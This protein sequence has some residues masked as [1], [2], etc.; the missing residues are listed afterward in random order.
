[1]VSKH[2]YAIELS[3]MNNQVY[4]LN[5][6]KSVKNDKEIK[7]T[8]INENLKVI[9][10]TLFYPNR[11]RKF[12]P[13]YKVLEA[14]HIKKIIRKY[15]KMDVV[16]SFST[17]FVNLKKFQ[18]DLTIYH[19]VDLSTD[20]YF[21]L[22]SE[23]SDFLLGV[24][25]DILNKFSKKKKYL[26]EHGLSSYF[27]NSNYKNYELD[28]ENIN[29]CYCGNMDSKAINKKI[30]LHLIRNY[31]KIKFHFI[32]PYNSNK[33]SDFIN[34]IDALKNSTLYGKKDPEEIVEIYTKMDVFLIAYDIESNNSPNKGANSHKILEY[35]STGKT[36]ISNPIKAYIGKPDLIEMT[37]DSS[38]ESYINLFDKI[39]DNLETFND[40]HKMKKRVTFAQN[41]S[42][43]NRI[44]QIEKIINS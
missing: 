13:I 22:I 21:I 19:P 14:I 16:W 1:M 18:S 7:H 2:H 25:N 11:L 6:P 8:I 15:G 43:K 9:D 40:I 10:H 39:I 38:F 17:Y 20:K 29:V 24:T 23:K 30:I 35:L 31:P 4:F 41:N 44:K 33:R 3:K 12:Y 28:F 26:I 42:Y 5:P 36:I 34:D 37:E 27:L 32:G